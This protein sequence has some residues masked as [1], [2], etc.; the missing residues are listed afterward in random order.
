MINYNNKQVNQNKNKI[1]A[2]LD[3]N[4][5][6]SES[7]SDTLSPEL[8]AYNTKINLSAKPNLKEINKEFY[9]CSGWYKDKEIFKELIFYTDYKDKDILKAARLYVKYSHKMN[10]QRQL[11]DDYF[12]Y[13]LSRMG[14]K[15]KLELFKQTF[16]IYN[17]K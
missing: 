7:E 11:L 6:Q 4:Q 10:K 17:K 8:H 13:L 3:L 5:R 14:F 16:K 1:Q 12:K 2:W 15:N 9:Y